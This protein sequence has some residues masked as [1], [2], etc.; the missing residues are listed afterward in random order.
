VEE[1]IQLAGELNEHELLAI[2]YNLLG[3][4][5]LYTGDYSK[6]IKYLN[7]G[8]EQ[9]KP[10]EKWDDIVYSTAILGLLRGMTGNYGNGMKTIAEAIRIARKNKIL[11]FEAMAFGYLGSIHFWY[12][13]WD[14]AINNCKKCIDISKKMD[15]SL[16]IIW[17]TFFKGA[18]LF[19]AGDR[20]NGLKIMEQAIEMMLNMDSVLALHFF[21]SLF[22]ENLA[23]HG[24]YA[25]A[26]SMNKKAME[27]G[28]S[29]QRWGSISSHRTMAV[30]AS[31]GRY[32][33]W[34]KVE[35]NM[36]KSLELS[37]SLGVLT[38]LLPSLYRFSDLLRKKGDM[39]RAQY[40]YHQGSALADQIGCH[41]S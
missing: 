29:G 17:A 1:C 31:A 10:F 36:K 23:L 28:Q 38:E 9:L 20:K 8:L 2:S 6:G 32:P 11:T 27:I 25:K 39:D 41:A 13:R 21:Y 22:A 35:V 40:Y 14:A 37:T 33:D 16:P 4:A 26:E 18:T 7:D 15:N 30:L 24:S 12:G 5:C 3:R 34:N 19:N